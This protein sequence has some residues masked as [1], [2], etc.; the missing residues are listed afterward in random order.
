[1]ERQVKHIRK[2][3]TTLLRSQRKLDRAYESH[4]M[5]PAQEARHDH[6]VE[7]ELDNIWRWLIDMEYEL[8]DPDDH[9]SM[10]SHIAQRI[11]RN[12]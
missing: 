9:C 5:T 10:L 4:S 7:K 6:I 12:V 2:S 3:L 1:M 11:A 8:I